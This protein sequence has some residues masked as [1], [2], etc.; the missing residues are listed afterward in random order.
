MPT[1]VYTFWVPSKEQQG[2]ERQQLSRNRKLRDALNNAFAAVESDRYTTTAVSF[3]F[4][5][6]VDQQIQRIERGGSKI[7]PNELERVDAVEQNII[8]AVEQI[9]QVPPEFFLARDPRRDVNTES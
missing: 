6:A 9:K 5:E 4:E 3:S 8:R 2:Q 1:W 7:R